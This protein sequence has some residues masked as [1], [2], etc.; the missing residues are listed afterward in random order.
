MGCEEILCNRYSNV[1][2]YICSKCFEEL[3]GSGVEMDI[4]TFM[5][6]KKKVRVYGF[7]DPRKTF[8]L[9]FPKI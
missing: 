1:Y 8:E 4:R 3:I 6:T 2:G 9:V 5:N 7:F